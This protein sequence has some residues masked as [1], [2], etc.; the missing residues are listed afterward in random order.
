MSLVL[1]DVP[2]EWILPARKFEVAVAEAL[3]DQPVAI[4]KCGLHPLGHQLISLGVLSRGAGE[5]IARFGQDTA[6]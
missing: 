2:L 5:E 3:V 6:A 4:A 1:V